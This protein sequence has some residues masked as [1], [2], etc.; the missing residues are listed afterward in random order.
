MMCMFLMNDKNKLI[1]EKVL[2]M[3]INNTFSKRN[4]LVDINVFKE[5]VNDLRTDKNM[6]KFWIEYQKSNT[7]AKD[8]LFE[9]T[10]DAVDKVVNCLN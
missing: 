1:D 8:I 2:V 7:Y 5:I 10:I 4:C 3:A 9:D 6:K